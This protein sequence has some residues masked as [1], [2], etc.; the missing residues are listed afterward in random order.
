MFQILLKL[1]SAQRIGYS[2][3]MNNKPGGGTQTTGGQKILDIQRKDA[4][5][6]YT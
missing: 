1:K 4:E 3:Y 2:K 5:S 6:G